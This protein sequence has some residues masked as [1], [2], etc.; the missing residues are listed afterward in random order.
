MK[1][2]TSKSKNV[3]NDTYSD[4]DIILEDAQVEIADSFIYLGQKHDL[5]KTNFTVDLEP[6]VSAKSTSF[7]PIHSPT[8]YLWGQNRLQ[9]S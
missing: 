3:A 4:P 8:P 5:S 9:V 7:W 2:K 6:I 1:F